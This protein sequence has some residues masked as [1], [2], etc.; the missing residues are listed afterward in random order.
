MQ[1]TSTR[2]ILCGWEK[3]LPYLTLCVGLNELCKLEHISMT[4]LARSVQYTGVFMCALVALAYPEAFV[5]S[6]LTVS[7]CAR[8][9]LMMSVTPKI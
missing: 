9:P 6:T 8:S 3:A 1:V 2:R 7:R 5:I 4:A